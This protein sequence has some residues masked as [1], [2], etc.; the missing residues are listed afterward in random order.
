M[1]NLEQV[2]YCGLY[3]GLC[4]QCNRIPQRAVLLRDAM[5]TE[6]YENW[7]KELPQFEEFWLF[8][9]NLA[10]SEARCSC[11]RGNCGPSF[12][13]IRKCARGKGIE[14]C[15]YCTEY[16]CQMILG[17]A[18]GYVSM[19]A[20]GQRMKVIGIDTWIQEQEER[21]KTGFSYSDI[22]VLPY[23]IPGSE[24]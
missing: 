24:L 1:A 21:R 7:G 3:C 23:Q 19:L 8:L 17:I 15:I 20:D 6:G 5:R 2:T 18:K 10:G 4:A 9:N 11:R 16:P 14:V 13:G 22:R 12:C